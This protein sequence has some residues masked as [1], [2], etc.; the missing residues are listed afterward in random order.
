MLKRI[1]RENKTARPIP[2]TE[3]CSCCNKKYDEEKK[4]W[5]VKLLTC[6]PK[7]LAIPILIVIGFIAFCFLYFVVWYLFKVVITTIYVVMGVSISYLM[8]NDSD[9]EE[10]LLTEGEAVK[11]AVDEYIEETIEEVT[12]VVERSLQSLRNLRG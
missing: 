11:E 9:D 6:F 2:G 8:D 5:T 10:P 3:W 1:V 12:D 4:H 7:V